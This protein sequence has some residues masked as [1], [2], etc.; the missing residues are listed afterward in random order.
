M[1]FVHYGIHIPNYLSDTDFLLWRKIFSL[2][3]PNFFNCSQNYVTV[4]FSTFLEIS[5]I[6]MIPEFMIHAYRN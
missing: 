3:G 6:L 4:P 2:H 5:E 1:M